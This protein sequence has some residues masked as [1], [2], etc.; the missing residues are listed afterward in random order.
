MRL[1]HL[2]FCPTICLVSIA[3]FSV[4]SNVCGQG[5]YA[6]GARITNLIAPSAVRVGQLFTVSV[7]VMYYIQLPQ[8]DYTQNL[9]VDIEDKSGSL[10]PVTASSCPG[11]RWPLQSSCTY[12]PSPF[13]IMPGTFVASFTLTAPSFVTA[14]NLWAR[15]EVVQANPFGA[16]PQ[17]SQVGN[18][19]VRQFQVQV[20]TPVPGYPST[21]VMFPF[22]LVSDLL[23]T[24]PLVSST[25]S[26]LA[27]TYSSAR[28]RCVA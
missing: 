20:T 2:R 6:T 18:H 9:L 13:D 17:F 15:A 8:T 5:V 27:V 19:T 1:G 4:I 28:P 25:G 14:W 11:A 10:L 24:R 7:T 21:L 23:L 3:L 26:R 12:L 22:L 16:P